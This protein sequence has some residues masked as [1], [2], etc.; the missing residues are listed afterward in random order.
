MTKYTDG[1]K[2]MCFGKIVPNV[3]WFY[4]KFLEGNTHDMERVSALKESCCMIKKLVQ[5]EM[6]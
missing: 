1:R 3:L 4:L 5:S 6:Q 2:M